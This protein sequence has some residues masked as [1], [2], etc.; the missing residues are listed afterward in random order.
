[1]IATLD[2]PIVTDKFDLTIYLTPGV[3]YGHL[4][5]RKAYT[6]ACNAG[7]WC[8]EGDAH[9]R[10]GMIFRNAIYDAWLSGGLEMTQA[11]DRSGEETDFFA[12]AIN[13]YWPEHKNFRLVEGHLILWGVA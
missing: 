12:A 3:Y 6:D 11:M 13:S 7:M 10:E 4:A 2:A 5:L 1:M 8:Q 9:F